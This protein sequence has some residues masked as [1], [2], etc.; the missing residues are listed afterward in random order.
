MELVFLL[1]HEN[2]G[3]LARWINTWLGLLPTRLQLILSHSMVFTKELICNVCTGL[4]P[5]SCRLLSLQ[6]R[7]NQRLILS[8]HIV[9]NLPYLW[10]GDRTRVRMKSSCRSSTCLR[11]MSYKRKNL[12][13]VSRVGD[14]VLSGMLVRK[15]KL[16]LNDQR[17]SWKTSNI[18]HTGV[19]LHW[20]FVAWPF[21][22]FYTST[23]RWW[24]F[25]SF[26]IT[27]NTSFYS[28]CN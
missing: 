13:V 16:I 11:R 21:Q 27:I 5:R 10:R 26:M 9:I 17:P 15:K 4:P 18:S 6:H 3:T 24:M 25:R 23:F 1:S 7:G 28:T 12:M 19:R 14:T 22:I 2:D 8:T 20:P